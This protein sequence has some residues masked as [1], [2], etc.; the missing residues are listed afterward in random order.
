MVTSFLWIGFKELSSE[1]SMLR[2]QE[3]HKEMNLMQMKYIKFKIYM[4][5]FNSQMN[6]KP[7]MDDFAKKCV[8]LGRL[9]K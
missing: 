4:Y 5:N 3:L 6:A 2:S 7:K 9:Q 8:F 1:R